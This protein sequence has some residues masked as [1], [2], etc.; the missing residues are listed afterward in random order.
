MRSRA[1]RGSARRSDRVTEVFEDRSAGISRLGMPSIHCRI[2]TRGIG[3]STRCTALAAM[4]LIV[5]DGHTPRPLYGKANGKSAAR[6]G[7][8][9]LTKPC[10]G[11][12][13]YG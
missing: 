3:S 6:S 12:L 5:H 13:H 4:R 9:A 7:Q 1:G 10:A 2:G 11:T 8:W